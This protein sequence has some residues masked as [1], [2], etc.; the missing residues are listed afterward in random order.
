VT[1][2]TIERELIDVVI[3][4]C[5]ASGKSAEYGLVAT[6]GIQLGFLGVLGVVAAAVQ[7]RRI[8][9]TARELARDNALLK[10][11]VLAR[12]SG[13]VTPTELWILDGWSLI[14]S[15]GEYLNLRGAFL[16]GAQLQGARMKGAYLEDV[17]ISGADLT[18]ADLSRANLT[19]AVMAGTNLFCANLQGANLT[20]AELCRADLRH[21]D[22]RLTRCVRTAFRGADLWN[23]YMWNVDV[24]QAFTDG[25]DFTRSDHLNKAI[26]FDSKEHSGDGQPAKRI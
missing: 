22:M 12:V 14:R 13:G 15:R 21:A 26:S 9:R 6:N 19:G 1:E 18:K 25:A 8:Y 5:G 16:R 23:A 24:S 17:D 2:S 20:E 10:T 11:L 4:E 3:E 7:D